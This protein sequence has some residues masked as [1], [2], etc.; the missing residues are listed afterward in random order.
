[1]GVTEVTVVQ[2][3]PAI[4]PVELCYLGWQESF[5]QLIRLVEPNI[6]DQL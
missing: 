6:P 1:M 2:A 5:E 4:M 3:M